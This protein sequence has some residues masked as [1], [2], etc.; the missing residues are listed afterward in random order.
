MPLT[1][2]GG[3]IVGMKSRPTRKTMVLRKSTV[4]HP[5]RPTRK[6]KTSVSLSAD[7]LIAVDALAGR[8]GRSAWIE[9]S[10]RASVRRAATRSRDQREL[11]L[12][13]ANA[14]TLNRESADARA[15]QA[16]WESE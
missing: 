11:E 9:R 5:A 8:S 12:L 2:Y 16:L 1:T 7:L 15:Y 3:I 10:V 13:N 14:E 4:G 6:V